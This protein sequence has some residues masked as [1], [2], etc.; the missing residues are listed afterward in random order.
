MAKGK[1]MNLAV[2]IS[3]KVDKS[4]TSA[5]GTATKAIGGFAGGVAKIGGAAI[6]GGAA[7]IT[8]IGTAAVGTTKAIVDATGKVAEYGDNIDKMSQKMG[9]SAEA[10]QEWDAI[11]Q[12]SG[13]SIEALKPSMKTLATQAEKGSDA[14]QKLGI[15]E[16]EVKN[17][18]QEEL[19][20][21]VI[22][23][24]QNMEEG[25]E[26]TYI[27][28][29]LLGKGATELGAL[30]NTSAEDTEKMRQR[31]HELG[32]VMSD[33]AVKAAATYQDQLQ[34]MQT[35]FQG[36]QRNLLSGFMPSITTVMSGLT[37]IFSGNYD[38]GIDTFSQGIN[39]VAAKITDTIPV[40]AEK[41]TTLITNL[42]NG[43][44]ANFPKLFNI[45]TQ[46]ITGL[47]NAIVTSLP[48]LGDAGLQ[49]IDSLV[50]TLNDNIPTI[51]DTAPEILN[52]GITLIGYLGQGIMSAL[53]SILS[54]AGTIIMYL[55]QGIITY[56]PTV[57][58]TA[59]III[60]NLIQGI[61]TQLPALLNTGLTIILGL[62]RGIADSLPTIATCALNIVTSLIMGLLPALPNVLSMGT[63][64]VNTLV[65]GV[66]S[67]LSAIVQLAPTIIKTL[68]TGLIQNLPAII[69]AAVKM[70]T[71]IPI[72][73]AIGVIQALPDIAMAVFEIQTIIW[74]TLLNTD[75]L[76][77][78]K[79]IID[80]VLGGIATN[81]SKIGDAVMGVV[82]GKGT[83]S[84]GAKT[85]GT[86]MATELASGFDMG[87]ADLTSSLDSLTKNAFANIDTSSALS[88]GSAMSDDFLSGLMTPTNTE[89]D[90][91][92]LTAG[93]ETQFTDLGTTA[94][95]DLTSGLTTQFADSQPELDTAVTGM[96]DS[97]NT[98][99]TTGFTNIKTTAQ[100]AMTE[101]TNLVTTEAQKAA[102]AVKQAFE[103]MT[104]TIPKPKIP[105]IAVAFSKVEDGTGGSVNVPNF[106]V[107]WNALGG[108]FDRATV[109]NTSQGLQGA[110][111]RGPEA[112]LPLDS[113]WSHL[114][115]AMSGAGGMNISY[116]PSYTINGNS[117]DF[118]QAAASSQK[119][120]E[121][122]MEEYEKKRSRINFSRW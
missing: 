85:A 7:A 114:E 40:I 115:G 65:N 26:R 68:I 16:Q 117:D 119:R 61:S 53:P 109:F 64:I 94:G 21:K 19:F 15:S 17:S 20:S 58:N 92:A 83:G 6:L 11:M 78:G 88:A 51:L 34:D 62:V 69:M 103:G 102:D 120:F 72:N 91:S 101:L 95:L 86:E 31:V 46:V 25:T 1:E 47:V 8:A 66:I 49:I 13:T 37:D 122:M 118:T 29:K 76:A 18:S 14:F 54:T 97:M 82:T 36:L 112:L 116:S 35:A 75:W 56:L 10:Y 87:S 89:I 55:A 52:L 4:F 105:Q 9:I 30:L 96:T 71:E 90:L 93:V 99:F 38:Q 12:H 5:I 70:G 43:N 113:L 44:I 22:T 98:Q 41:G 27:T 23:G 24:L 74:D 59:S 45:G 2:S 110:G 42:I 28:S 80:G 48:A 107:N 39:E 57:L 104:I 3:G 121:K 106:S 84:T 32:G 108:I 111:E 100:T 79:Q 60:T 77:L 50:N 81:V 63:Q 67:T 33:E 73:L